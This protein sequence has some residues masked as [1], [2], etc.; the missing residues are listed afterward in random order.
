MRIPQR[1]VSV[2]AGAH[3]R[4]F[5]TA[6][7][8]RRSGEILISHSTHLL[9]HGWHILSASAKRDS[10]TPNLCVCSRHE[11]RAI[12]ELTE[13]EF[14]DYR[15]AASKLGRYV[16]D[17]QLFA[18]VYLNYVDFK[19]L[20]RKSFQQYVNKSPDLPTMEILGLSVNRNLLNFLSSVRT[21]LDH[22]E[23]NLKKRYGNDH[24][25]VEEY[26]R[27]CSCE[28]DNCFSYR[29]VYQLRNYTQHCGMPLG[30][31]KFESKLKDARTDS[32]AHSLAIYFNRDRL[33]S[34]FDWGS[35]LKQE[36]QALPERF[37]ISWHVDQAMM[38]LRRIGKSLIKNDL[39]ELSKSARIIRDLIAPVKRRSG[40]P[41]IV[42]MTKGASGEDSL[43]VSI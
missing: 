1:S 24:E 22:S 9:V 32:I 36:I 39:A 18:I 21:F 7:T 35:K 16:H 37:E 14:S 6:T 28:Y 5:S 19:R 17:Q 31:L 38:C 20:L 8:K 15:G 33:L 2:Y 26:K 23:F 29:F 13:K 12:R 42:F 40:E 10:E 34:E 11:I 27:A 30:E 43:K 3:T 41:C 25:R 4:Y